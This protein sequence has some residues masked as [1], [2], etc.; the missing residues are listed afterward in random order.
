VAINSFDS[1]SADLS[2]SIGATVGCDYAGTVVTVSSSKAETELKADDRV[3]GWVF[4]NNP[5][6]LDNGAFAEFTAA[7]ADLLMRMTWKWLGCVAAFDYRAPSCAD[8]I[9]AASGRDLELALDCVTSTE[10]MKLCYQVI[11]TAGGRYVSL[12][13]FPLRSHARRSKWS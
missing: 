9:I 1:K 2:P 6:R 12:D 13:P 11:G 8:D 5:D 7:P 3:C 10:S 4:D